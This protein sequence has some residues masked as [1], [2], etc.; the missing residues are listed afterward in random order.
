[1]SRQVP[2]WRSLLPLRGQTSGP[3][4]LTSN[5][6]LTAILMCAPLPDACNLPGSCVSE[7]AEEEECL[8]QGVVQARDTGGTFI[9]FDEEPPADLLFQLKQGKTPQ[10]IATG[11][12]TERVYRKPHKP[13]EEALLSYD[14]EDHAHEVA[15][16]FN[17]LSAD[18]P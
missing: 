7:R 9:D 13:G 4:C 2:T 6:S 5:L 14:E 15:N 17:E 11:P 18:R 10:E 3:V 12:G 16:A 8:P 1:M